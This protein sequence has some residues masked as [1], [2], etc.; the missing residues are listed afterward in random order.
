MIFLMSLRYTERIKY[1]ACLLVELGSNEG[2]I[3]PFLSL[4]GAKKLEKG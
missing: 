4:V 2:K 3:F 1:A